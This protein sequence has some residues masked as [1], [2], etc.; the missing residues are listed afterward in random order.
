VRTPGDT[1]RRKSVP[2]H[3]TRR[4]CG[5][6][7][8]PT[9]L[10]QG[11]EELEMTQPPPPPTAPDPDRIEIDGGE[12][13]GYVVVALDRDVDP[14]PARDLADVLAAS[15]VAPAPARLLALLAALG[16][17]PTAAWSP[18]APA[19][20][21]SR[22]ARRARNSRQRPATR[23][24]AGSIPRPGSG[25]RAPPALGP[26]PE[27][28]RGQADVHPEARIGHTLR[29]GQR[30][31]Q[32][33][34]PLLPVDHP[35]RPLTLGYVEYER[36]EGDPLGR[37]RA[38]PEQEVADRVTTQDAVEETPRRH[39]GATGS[40]AGRTAGGSGPNARARRGA[41]ASRSRSAPA[42]LAS[43]PPAR[44][45]VTRSDTSGL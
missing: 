30:P 21:C 44:S 5:I 10:S 34:D 1:V 13:N 32:T 27:P 26:P 35:Q 17:P 11:G 18:P 43:P 22:S 45:V 33:G 8:A 25:A 3:P 7:T 37:S 6:P 31:D 28:Q 4:T 2:A 12:P 29:R 42:R 20:R 38:F 9:P 40:H 19:T 23:A 36:A 24:P 15:V 14:D 16:D 41:L 39:P